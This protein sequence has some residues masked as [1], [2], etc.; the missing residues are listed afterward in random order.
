[1]PVQPTKASSSHTAVHTAVTDVLI[2]TVRHQRIGADGRIPY[3][4]RCEALNSSM[5][6]DRDR[7]R[8]ETMDD[9]GD[10]PA[11]YTSKGKK[12]ASAR[13]MERLQ[14]VEEHRRHDC[15][16]EYAYR[17]AEREPIPQHVIDLQR[18]EFEQNQS[19]QSDQTANA[20]RDQMSLTVEL[21]RRCTEL[22][23]LLSK[24]QLSQGES[25][26]HSPKRLQDGRGYQGD[27]R[28]IDADLDDFLEEDDDYPFARRNWAPRDR[29]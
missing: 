9:D 7:S 5:G 10:E 25:R 8:N 24:R 29:E 23:K 12:R 2:R 20:L 6:W 15:D 17:R 16:L 22:E 21:Q 14:E 19:L 26:G 28:R 13:D 3:T 11:R 18:R 4:V 1:M 27:R